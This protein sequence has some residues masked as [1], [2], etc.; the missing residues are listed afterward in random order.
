[1]RQPLFVFYLASQL[2]GFN[3]VFPFAVTVTSAS[4]N[5][6]LVVDVNGGPVVSATPLPNVNLD[7]GFATTTVDLSTGF[8]D[9]EGDPL[10]YSA[11]T[12]DAELVDTDGDGDAGHLTR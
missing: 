4:V 6:T 2:A 11:V 3:N 12:T 8:D 1:L 10:T 9:P 7:E 5:D